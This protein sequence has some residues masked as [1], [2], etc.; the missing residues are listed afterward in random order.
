M[1]PAFSPGIAPASGTKARGKGLK[2][3]KQLFQAASFVR[4]PGRF[5]TCSPGLT[6]CA[7]FTPQVIELIKYKK[8]LAIKQTPIRFKDYLFSAYTHFWF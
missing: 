2:Y 8:V 5:L 4:T 3:K 6:L 1:A 7:V